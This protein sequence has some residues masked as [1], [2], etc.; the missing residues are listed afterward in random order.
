MKNIV[1]ILSLGIVGIALAL[2][3]CGDGRSGS[4]TKSA[5]A[6]PGQATFKKYCVTC[7]GADG[8]MGLNGAANLAIST[9]SKEESVEVIT[10]GRKLMAPY[11]SILSEQEISQVADHVL[12]LRQ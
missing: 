10:N 1:A 8:K 11:K 2:N 5:T 7:H 4:S 3:G 6:N 12:T 9:L